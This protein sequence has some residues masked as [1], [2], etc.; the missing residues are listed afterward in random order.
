M[1]ILLAIP[2]YESIEP[3]TFKSVYDMATVGQE[4]DFCFV[5]GYDCAKARNNIA[6]QAVNENYDYVLMVD[7]DIILP[8]EA[9][10]YLTYPLTD[11]CFGVYPRKHTLT[12]QTELF[13]LGEEDYSDSNNISISELESADYERIEVK[14]G[15]LGCALVNTDVFRTLEFPWFKYVT[16]PNGDVLSEDLYFCCRAS[17]EGYKLYADKRVR[18]GHVTKAAHYW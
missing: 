4:V 9:L 17:A 3:D 13:R 8:R 10:I 5:R 15:G 2:T 16:Y 11:I 18:C 14:G 12:G 1:R 6:Q 7:S